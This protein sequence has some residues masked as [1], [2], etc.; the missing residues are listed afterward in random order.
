MQCGKDDRCEP[1]KHF[2]A[3]NHH[4]PVLDDAGYPA[5]DTHSAVAEHQ[6]ALEVRECL[7]LQQEVWCGGVED[8]GGW[9]VS[10]CLDN[11]GEVPLVQIEPDP[12]QGITQP[13]ARY[14]HPDG[15]VTP[16]ESFGHHGPSNG[17]QAWYF[18]LP[19]PK[20]THTLGGLSSPRRTSSRCIS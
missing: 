2:R 17:H 1:L 6:D 11:G 19:S 3:R 15:V 10:R 8:F 14:R 5:Q 16:S 12:L 13:V 9:G 20:G 7:K 18:V 4:A